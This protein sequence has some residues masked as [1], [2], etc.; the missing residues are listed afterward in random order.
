MN[1]NGSN[2][3]DEDENRV[4]FYRGY[5]HVCMKDSI[6]FQPSNVER[7]DVELISVLDTLPNPYPVL[8]VMTEVLSIPQ[9]KAFG[10]SIVLVRRLLED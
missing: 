9:L 6:L 7:H 8:F 4:S 5:A 1:L 3:I 10:S 2:I